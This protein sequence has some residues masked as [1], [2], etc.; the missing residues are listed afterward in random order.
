MTYCSACE[1]ADKRCEGANS[2]RKC[3][4]CDCKTG[5]RKCNTQG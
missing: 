5:R 1:T 4:K 3:P 2:G